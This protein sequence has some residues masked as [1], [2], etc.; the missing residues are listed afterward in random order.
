[1]EMSPGEQK[2][3]AATQTP[4]KDHQQKGREIE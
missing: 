3:L 2:R 4:V 1:M